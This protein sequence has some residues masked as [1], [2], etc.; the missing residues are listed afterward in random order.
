MDLSDPAVAVP[1]GEHVPLLS[2]IERV[3]FSQRLLESVTG[4]LRLYVHD[5]DPATLFDSL[6][7]D[8]LSLTDSEFGYIAEVM[9]DPH[10]VP[11][12]RTWSVTNIAWDAETR[13]LYEQHAVLGGGLEFRNLETLF[14][15]SL[16]TEQPVIANAPDDDPRAGG[17]P[18]GHPPLDSFLAVP[19][20]HGS[21]IVGQFGVANRRGG[22]DSCVVD[23]LAPFTTALG[24]LIDAY[25]SDAAHR[26][27]QVA[28]HRSEQRLAML[29]DQLNDIITILAA[30]GSWIYSSPGG[31]RL[32][33]YPPGFDIDGGI[34]GL[35]HP[36]DVALAQS[37][38]AEV[39]SGTR[40]PRDSVDLRVRTLDGSYRVLETVGVDLL[41]DPSIE[42]VVLT[43]HD[44]TAE[45]AN[46]ER[47]LEA[48]SQLQA[49]VTNL[50]DGVLFVDDDRHIMFANQA[51]CDLFEIGMPPRA[52][53][54]WST[55]DIRQHSAA[56]T[57]DPEAFVGRVEELYRTWQPAAGD[58]LRL[59][60]GRVLERDYVPVQLD[61][62]RRGHLWLYRDVTQRHLLDEQR[63]AVLAREREMRAAIEQQNAALRELSHLKNEFIA[64]VSHELRT[65]LTSIVSFASLL[66]DDIDQLP[67]G[68]AEFVEVVDR[69]AQRLMRVVDDLL[70]AA[71]LQ[72]GG[73]T[74]DRRPVDLARLLASA[75]GAA[76]AQAELATVDLQLDIQ[77]GPGELLDGDAGRLDQLLVN[78]LS[79][80][81]KFTLPGG[82]VRVSA[83]SSEWGWIIE[84]ADSGIGIPEREQER[85]FRRFYR[86]SNAAVVA[87]GTGL[88]LVICQAIVELHGGTIAVRSTEGV[89]TT[90]TVALPAKDR[91]TYRD[92][93]KRLDPS[94]GSSA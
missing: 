6:L 31:T 52:L 39:V 48:T 12:L 1:R 19:I 87:P 17:R 60:N 78:L 50:R 68:H 35:L 38:F 88:G 8:L 25:R 46:A 21:Q 4:A 63:N 74:M 83:R 26:D 15:R 47:V 36:D 22:Y 29:V 92:R 14:G 51:M 89:G 56:L 9:H 77:A 34:F 81:L 76:R 41:H 72:S 59:H 86:G 65:P 73:I 55:A 43:S 44:V 49:L 57:T 93:R 67:A 58:E 33:G 90:V 24:N 27:V 66:R 20:W 16:T 82:T 61:A 7:N 13:S 18:P 23:D 84:V 62:D 75:V 32:L 69:N 11:Y 37:A 91:R 28:L 54:G 5:V 30:D 80:A 10:G 71:K 42:G 45:R 85:L 79:N 40:G 94:T 70:D 3:A 64:D 2:D 53:V